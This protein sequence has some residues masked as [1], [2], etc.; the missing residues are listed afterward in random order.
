MPWQLVDRDSGDLVVESLELADR[1]WTRLVGLQF[2]A[3]LPAG[4]GLLLVPCASIHTCCLRFPL[5]VAML[6]PA[7][8]VL[9]VR[10]SVHPWRIVLAP[11]GTHAVLETAGGSLNLRLRQRLRLRDPSGGTMPK[12]L[13]FLWE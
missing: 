12:S 3:A 4:R 6:D 9:A 13:L 2:R 11:H 7:G 8:E 1:Y 10:R 5:D